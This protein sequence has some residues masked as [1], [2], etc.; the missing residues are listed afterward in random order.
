MRNM[1]RWGPLR[2]AVHLGP[3]VGNGSRGCASH[4][5]CCRGVL[6]GYLACRVLI[7][8]L[9]GVYGLKQSTLWKKMPLIPVWDALALLVWLTSFMKKSIRWR[10]VDYQLESGT[11]HFVIPDDRSASH[12]ST[13][14][15][16]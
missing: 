3:A 4:A 13:R 12:V 15:D 11:G 5:G 1:R 7:T 8:W 6:G 2:P 10:G 14:A 16:S 9:I